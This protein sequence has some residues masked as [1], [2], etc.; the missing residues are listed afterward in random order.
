MSTVIPNSSLD[1]SENNAISEL[2]SRLDELSR[3]FS[4]HKPIERI[5]KY[6]L[7]FWLTISVVLGFFGFK[8]LSDIDDRVG[9]KVAQLLPKEKRKFAEF[10]RLV[11]DSAELHEKYVELLKDYQGAVENLK[12]LR[13]VS[14]DFDIQG[15]ILAIEREVDEPGNVENDKWRSRAI[16]TIQIFVESLKHRSYPSDFIFNLA[17]TCRKLEQNELLE[18]L[19][20]AA[21]K[22]DPNPQNA[23]FR[24]AARVANRGDGERVSALKQLMEKVRQINFFE[25]PQI[26]LGEAWN[27]AEASRR[28]DLLLDA[29]ELAEKEAEGK[30]LPSYFWLIKAQ[31]QLRLSLPG[32]REAARLSLNSAKNAFSAESMHSQWASQFLRE[33]GEVKQLVEQEP[34]ELLRV[35]DNLSGEK[36]TDW[37]SSPLGPSVGDGS[38][39]S[40]IARD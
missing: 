35:L 28:Y 31:A 24:L 8:E 10:S 23:A 22:A 27:G 5:V 1:R 13:E 40:E 11:Q 26:V 6:L 14:A 7:Y 17:Q 39:E 21:F 32:S 36:N 20:E 30:A 34:S 4:E 12:L 33:Y 9:D 16:T 29:L 15:R 37:L 38:G 19:A 25:S 3:E 18:T 2:S